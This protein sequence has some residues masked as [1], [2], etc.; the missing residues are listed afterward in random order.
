MMGHV[1]H[2]TIGPKH[3]I[4]LLRAHYKSR[5]VGSQSGVYDGRFIFKPPLHSFDLPPLGY[6]RDRQRENLPVSTQG[7][8][9]L[10]VYMLCCIIKV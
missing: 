10:Y 9:Y 2:H 3:L 8:K 7:Y 5:F 6:E 4:K 1:T